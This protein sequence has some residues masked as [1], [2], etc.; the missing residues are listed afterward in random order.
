M[1]TVSIN[2]FLIFIYF[3]VS[4]N[5]GGPERGGAKNPKWTLRSQAVRL[6]L[7]NQEVMT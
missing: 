5:R 3:G 1:R 2:S 4:A 6:K 7:M